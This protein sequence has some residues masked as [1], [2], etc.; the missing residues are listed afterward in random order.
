MYIYVYIYVQYVY[1]CVYTYQY[2][3]VY[4]YRHI[5]EPISKIAETSQARGTAEHSQG[6]PAGCQWWWYRWWRTWSWVAVKEFKLQWFQNHITAEILAK[7]SLLKNL[8]GWMS[9]HVVIFH[10]WVA[11]MGGVPLTWELEG[12][13][14]ESGRSLIGTSRAKN[15][16]AQIL[17]LGFAN[18][19]L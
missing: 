1:A 6:G 12:S 13:G 17:H 9:T 3:N 2:V 7:S 8:R 19:D 4:I 14:Y 10:L 5:P 16:K 15:L 11:C 18:W